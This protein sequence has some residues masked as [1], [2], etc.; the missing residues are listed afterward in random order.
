MKI[1][2]ERKEKYWLLYFEAIRK[3]IGEKN[4][5]LKKVKQTTRFLLFSYV[6]PKNEIYLRNDNRC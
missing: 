2:N 6:C 3:Q 4:E 1:K 5:G